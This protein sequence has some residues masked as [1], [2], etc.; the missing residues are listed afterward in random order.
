MKELDLCFR[1]NL[2][3]GEKL[4]KLKNKP[5]IYFIME[6]GGFED[7]NSVRDEEYFT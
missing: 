2:W 4:D 6:K 3:R 7:L 1:M 5:E